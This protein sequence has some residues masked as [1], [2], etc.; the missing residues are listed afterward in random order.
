MGDGT[1]FGNVIDLLAYMTLTTYWVGGHT[2]KSADTR[3][4]DHRS[5]YVRLGKGRKLDAIIA[6]RALASSTKA[7]RLAG[8][9][10]R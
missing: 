7:F 5:S 10:P 1:L 8:G 6:A 2:D 4:Y 9:W 3:F